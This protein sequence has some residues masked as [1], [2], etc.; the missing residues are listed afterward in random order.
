MF[1]GGGGFEGVITPAPLE[2]FNHTPFRGMLGFIPFPKAV[3]KSINSYFDILL[4]NAFKVEQK[5]KYKS[6]LGI[7]AWCVQ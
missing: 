2:N 3:E 4:D 5:V 7:T 6:D 1:V